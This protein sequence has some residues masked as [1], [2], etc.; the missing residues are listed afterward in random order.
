MHL[1]E[2]NISKWNIIQQLW[3]DI[4]LAC[5]RQ[6]N[7]LIIWTN[8]AIATMQTAGPSATYKTLAANQ[9]HIKAS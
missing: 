7:G 1:V 2:R 8:K 4:A 9:L 6:K 3:D 5:M